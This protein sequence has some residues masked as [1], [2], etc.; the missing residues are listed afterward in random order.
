MK[1]LNKTVPYVLILVVFMFLHGCIGQEE[2]SSE[3]ADGSTSFNGSGIPYEGADV[4]VQAGNFQPKFQFVPSSSFQVVADIRLGAGAYSSFTWRDLPGLDQSLNNFIEY[5]TWR[6]D[7]C[8]D[9]VEEPIYWE[10][11]CED[12]FPEE[13]DQFIDGL[14]DNG[15]AV[16]YML[17]FWDKT[18]HANG[19]EL[20]TP[21]FQSEEQIQDFLDYVRFVVSHYKDRVQYYTIWSEPDAGGIKHILVEDYINLVRRTVPVIHE[22]DPQAKVS[23]APNVL[24]FAREYLSAILESDIMTMVDVIQWHGIYNVLPND[25]FWEGYYYQYPAIIEGIQQTAAAHGFDGEYWATEISYCSEEFPHCQGLSQPWGLPRTDKQAAKYSSRAIVMHLGWDIGVAMSTWLPDVPEM[26]PWT[27]PTT[28]NLYKVLAG[29]RP[30]SLAVRI[31]REPTNTLTNTFALPNGDMLFALWTHGEAI[32]DDPGVSTTLLFPG[33]S[34]QQ[35]IAIDV[36]NGFEQELIIEVWTGN[37][38]IRNLFVRDYPL[39]LRI[40]NPYFSPGSPIAIALIS[41][42]IIGIP[43]IVVSVYFFRKR[44]IR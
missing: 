33:L 12:E 5:G 6:L 38:V 3:L 39:I 10:Y 22:E 17:H 36:L 19:E 11:N 43:I 13:Y 32:D 21:R 40:T 1:S 35:V 28:S 44:R 41:G 24:F 9:E 26:A 25:S 2:E 14:I 42:L 20:S 7:T 31:E 18:G 4:L 34:A 29:T 27:H 37:L 23:I 30:I 8:V 15:I 16:N